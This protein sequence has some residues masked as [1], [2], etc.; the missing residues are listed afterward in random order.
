M[1]EHFYAVIM[2]GGEGSRLWPLSRRERPKQMVQLASDQSLFQ[3]AVDRISPI[4]PPERIYV[5]TVES[6]AVKLQAQCTEIPVENFLIEPMPRGTASVVGLAALALHQRDPQA[7]MVILAADHLIS[8]VTYFQQLL[9]EGY[10][11]AEAGML[12][13]LGIHPTYPATGY[14]YIQRGEELPGFP[15]LSFEVKRFREKPDE[16]TARDFL[17]RGDHFWNS[18][19]FL[20]RTDRIR[21]EFARHMPELVAQLGEIEQAWD[22]PAR[23]EVLTT[24]WLNIKPQTIDYGIMEK[25]EQVAVIPAADLGWNDVGS[26]ES[27]FEVFTP[28]ENGN[29]ILDAQHI[30]IKTGSSLIVSDGTN[31]LVVTLGVEDLIVVDTQDAILVC[32]RDHAQKVREVVNLLKQQDGGKRFL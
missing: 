6:Q 23:A 29:I 8:N 30:G 21:E 31:R 19:M 25:A 1:F 7:V 9:R 24:T 14:G 18:G 16:E 12:V 22:T 26:W 10:T 11:L 3:M 32:A 5:V 13:T 27:I 4:F 17:A 15:F 28:D 20:W 2:A